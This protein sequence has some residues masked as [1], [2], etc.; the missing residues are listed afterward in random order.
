MII[1]DFGDSMCPNL[2]GL[3][4]WYLKRWSGFDSQPGS[5]YTVYSELQ[6]NNL[7]KHLFNQAFFIKYHM[8][9]RFS[10]WISE[11]TSLKWILQLSEKYF[12]ASHFIVPRP[13]PILASWKMLIHLALDIFNS[14]HLFLCWILLAFFHDTI[15]MF[16]SWIN[17]NN[18]YIAVFAEYFE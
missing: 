9:Y 8:Y 18:Y 17:T 4:E 5:I 11:C 12:F 13:V 10:Y 15:Y 14:P 3:M 7:I 16:Q 1:R 2:G 6:I